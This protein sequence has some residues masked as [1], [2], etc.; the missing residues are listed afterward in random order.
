MPA[1][2]LRTRVV[3][4]LRDLQD[5]ITAGLERADGGAAFRE[6]G[7]ERPG[8]GGGR[9]RVLEEGALFERAGV[10]FSEVHG[11]VTPQM[12]S[13]M[14][15]DGSR[16]HATG[17][18]LV[19]HPRS[20]RVPTVH[21]NFRF[22]SRGSAAWFG[23][24]AD[25]TP[26]YLEPE[27]AASF[28]RVWKDVCDRYDPGAYARFKDECD[29][30]FFNSHRG[31]ARGVGGIFFDY[32]KHDLERTF[33]FVREGGDSFLASYLPIVER[34]R[35]EPWGERERDWQCLRRGRYVEFNLIHDRGTTF[36]L[37]TGGRTESILMSLPPLVKWRYDHS[38][39]PG[40][41]EAAL[42]E[43]LR[44]PRAWA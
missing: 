25:L 37:R 6:D 3:A 24:G 20:P 44:N 32:L 5:R 12:E 14:P 33:D 2:E 17:V 11:D 38:P 31:E 1:N 22:L 4:Y 16:F 41:P 18:S 39:P 10:N 36:G 9:S 34:R 23:G 28:H 27:D 29:R 30:Y 35:R 40:S 8:G 42:V 43:V 15:G 13:V 26:Y 7:W 21:A 19:L